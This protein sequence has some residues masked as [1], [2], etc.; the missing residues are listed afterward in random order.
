MDVFRGTY[1]R[2]MQ[3][4]GKYSPLRNYQTFMAGVNLG[5]RFDEAIEV[6]MDGTFG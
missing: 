5:Q 6:V 1:R 3:P 2:K 4:N